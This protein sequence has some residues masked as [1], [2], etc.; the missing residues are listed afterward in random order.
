M[1]HSARRVIYV[2]QTPCFNSRF[3][4]HMALFGDKKQARFYSYHRHTRLTFL[5]VIQ[6][7]M[8][9]ATR[10]HIEQQLIKFLQ[11][12]MNTQSAELK[13][14]NFGILHTVDL[15]KK[16]SKLSSKVDKVRDKE[17]REALEFANLLAGVSTIRWTREL[18]IRIRRGARHLTFSDIKRIRDLN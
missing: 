6:V 17:T 12:I 14:T 3:R 15:S 7:S 1:D 2:G 10:L 18:I 4:Q 16:P 11:P 5:P 9:E 8:T 13:E